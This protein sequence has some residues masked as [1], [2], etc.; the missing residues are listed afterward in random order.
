MSEGLRRLGQVPIPIVFGIILFSLV[1]IS[2]PPSYAEE[3][4]SL[5]KGVVRIKATVAGNPN[6]GT[7]FIVRRE[8]SAAYIVTASHVVEGGRDV[9][10]E[11]FTNR[12]RLV[13]ARVIAIE[14]DDPQGLAVLFVTGEIPTDISVLMLN[15]EM[16]VRAGDPVTMIG[17]PGLGAAPW[18]VTQG[19]IVGRKGKNILFSGVVEKGSSGGPLLKNN[20]VVGVITK[21]AS[22][23]AYATA[24]VIA[25]YALESWGIKFGMRLR[26]EPAAMTGSGVVHIIRMKGFHHPSGRLPDGSQGGIIGNFGHEYEVRAGSDDT[27][28]IDRATELMWQQSGSQEALAF[29]SEAIRYIHDLN[30]SRFGGVEDW[31]LPTLEELMSLLEP[32]GVNQGLYVGQRFSSDQWVCWSSDRADD[33]G[34]SIWGVNFKQGRVLPLRVRNTMFVRAV[35]SLKPS[36]RPEM[37]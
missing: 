25:R 34:E 20:Q 1:W 24:S 10:V 28:I 21:K 9:A 8:A 36:D 29:Q 31:R 30:V 11:F 14:G 37:R 3:I 27:V 4:E 32:F 26:R 15:L 7:G 33:T 13:P 18:T 2:P 35:R 17:F 22:Q 16:P 5:K 19:E 6:Q 12:N 23:F